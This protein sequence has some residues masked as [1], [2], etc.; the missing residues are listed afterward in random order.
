VLIFVVGER[1]RNDL[2][3]AT[4][5][6]SCQKYIDRRRRRPR[7]RPTLGTIQHHIYIHLHINNYLCT[8]RFH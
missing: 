5:A 7:P 3:I 6:A 1:V 4:S 8:Y 2:I